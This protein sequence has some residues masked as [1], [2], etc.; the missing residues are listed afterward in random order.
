MFPYFRMNTY[1]LWSAQ[2]YSGTHFPKMLRRLN[3]EAYDWDENLLL[4]SLRRVIIK[5]IRELASVEFA[6]TR[7]VVSQFIDNPQ[8]TG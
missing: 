3:R 7:V 5:K 1:R 2:N 4:Q 6:E 8:D